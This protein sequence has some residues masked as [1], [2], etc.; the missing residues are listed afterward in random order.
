MSI[1]VKADSSGIDRLIAIL[2]S[3]GNNLDERLLAL[4]NQTALEM[5]GD[6]ASMLYGPDP[7]LEWE[8]GET[9][10]SID[11]YCEKTEDG[12]SFGVSTTNLRTIYHEM[13]TGPVGMAHGYPGEKNLDEPIVWRSTPWTGPFGGLNYGVPAK[14]A[15][16]NAVMYAKPSVEKK[17]RELIQEVLSGR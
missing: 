12:V 17:V 2:E 5:R 16:H 3:A 11:A 8:S 4:G 9:G 14:A 7:F 13:G 1:K 15:M 10:D 6:A